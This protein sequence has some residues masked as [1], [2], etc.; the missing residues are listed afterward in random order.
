MWACH[1]LGFAVLHPK[2]SKGSKEET[3]SP[4]C[5]SHSEYSME[6]K[7]RWECQRLFGVLN[8]LIKQVRQRA[9]GISGVYL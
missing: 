7:V 4:L 2:P 5:L 3:V 1:F 9:G 6:Q 8:S